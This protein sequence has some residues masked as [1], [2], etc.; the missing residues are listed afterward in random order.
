MVSAWIYGGQIVAQR[1]IVKTV[2]K[3][4]DAVLEWIKNMAAKAFEVITNGIK[5]K[6]QSMM[7]LFEYLGES[8]YGE[9]FEGKE[10]NGAFRRLSGFMGSPFMNLMVTL[11]VV[12]SGIYLAISAASMGAG[13]VAMSILQ[14]YLVQLIINSI[15]SGLQQLHMNIPTV[16][17]VLALPRSLM[18]SIVSAES[19]RKINGG[20]AA[21]GFAGT[22]LGTMIAA[23]IYG[24]PAVAQKAIV[25]ASEI[26]SQAF[27][28]YATGQMNIG[29]FQD[30]ITQVQNKLESKRSVFGRYPE[31]S[32]RLFTTPIKNLRKSIW[33]S[34]N[35]LIGGIIGLVAEI[36]SLVIAQQHG[37]IIWQALA[38]GISLGTSV[39]TLYISLKNVIKLPANFG[40]MNSIGTGATI[41]SL[42]S[43]GWQIGEMIKTDT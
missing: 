16:N 38:S 19:L 12:I 33:A 34:K 31:Y 20:V 32:N 36:V 22:F 3:G 26:L 29:E 28:G 9:I 8:I 10:N 25:E 23:W 42:L 6:M 40:L 35:V 21:M 43:S 41:I 2:R 14:G 24:G 7:N 17:D 27:E 18:M 15:I 30:M 4:F 39:Y 37:S 5:E 13:A 1:A 11:P